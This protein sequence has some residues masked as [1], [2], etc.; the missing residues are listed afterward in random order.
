MLSQS[1]RTFIRTA[2]KAA[3][4]GKLT[5]L[6]LILMLGIG[7]LAS[8]RSQAGTINDVF[9]GIA[10]RV[11]EF[12]GVHIDA[13]QDVLYVHLRN[14]TPAMAQAV[15]AELRIAFGDQHLRQRSVQ[16]LPATFGFS[17]LKRWHD[18]MAM[19]VLQHSGVTFIGIDHAN[20]RLV[21]GVEDS[22]VGS[23]VEHV[24]AS[25]GLPRAA[26]HLMET[27]PLEHKHDLSAFHRPVV[28]SLGIATPRGSC[29]LGF[30]AIRAGVLGF[31]T[32]AHCSSPDGA[33]PGREGTV[34]TQGGSPIGIETRD[35]GF[36]G[37]FCTPRVFGFRICLFRCRNS[38]SAF[39][40]LNQP[41]DAALGDIAATP[42]DFLPPGDA[43]VAVYLALLAE[44]YLTF[45][46]VTIFGPSIRGSTDWDDTSVFRIEGRQTPFPGLRV[47]KV[48]ATSGLTDGLVLLT[49]LTVPLLTRN[50]PFVT[51][52]LLRDQA[53]AGYLFEAGD[54]GAPVFNVPIEERL[55]QL[56]EGGDA[57]ASLVGIAWAGFGVVIPNFSGGA[58]FSPI[59]GVERDLGPLTFAV[60]PS[61]GIAAT[62]PSVGIAATS[63]NADLVATSSPGSTDFCELVSDSDR[64]VRV[65]VVNR[66]GTVAPA[67]TTRVDFPPFTSFNFPTVEIPPGGFVDLDPIEPPPGCF[68][69]DCNFVITVDSTESVDEGSAAEANNT[70][71]G[72]C[73]G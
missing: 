25:L 62:S 32:A 20:N 11:P 46:G 51:R 4:V 43:A 55:E 23:S 49:G 36:G 41:M 53:L 64:R 38:D 58:L 63:P 33:A 60:S 52:R 31:V 40:R 72:S 14:G 28:G 1:R 57:T 12:G 15:L 56:Q 13:Q 35:P 67:S 5:R 17:E 71:V 21:I 69:P 34:Y 27:G 3:R 66:G 73:P 8:G 54:S 39:V 10:M 48:G 30:N 19:D 6:G 47:T 16:V 44:Q 65:R 61:V 29:S 59:S 22:N 9:A 37:C 7:A 50:F 26:V 45:P 2:T 68:N 70:A 24:L 18:H 42:F